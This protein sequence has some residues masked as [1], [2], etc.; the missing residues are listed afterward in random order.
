MTGLRAYRVSDVSAAS[1]DMGSAD[2]EALVEDIREHGQLVPICVRG[3]EIID[4]RKRFAAC[5]RL[6]IEP[7]TVNIAKDQDPEALS[8]S[9][10]IYRTH[11]TV[12]QRAM[13]ASKRVNSTQGS[14]RSRKFKND[15]F[16]DLVTIAD[17]AKEAAVGPAY[18]QRAKHVRRS[19]IPEVAAAIEAGN[20]TLHAAK[21]I[22]DLPKDEQPAALEHK[23][24][25]KK[26]KGHK[27]ANAP[28]KRSK[29]TPKRSPTR[30]AADQIE[31]AL[32]SLEF[33]VNH[34]AGIVGD[35][36]D[37]RDWPK[38]LRAVRTILSRIIGEMEGR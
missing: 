21:K 20:L 22:A 36:N 34:I 16:T 30:P 12:S 13:L 4:G 32:D 26:S 25:E 28:K 35:V 19:A 33:H 31:S 9:L 17:A 7:K 24:E 6:G 38:R 29:A 15:K 10:N 37:Y 18:V 3:D 27:P 14:G 2:F 1:P 5:E 11:Y 8:R 23:L